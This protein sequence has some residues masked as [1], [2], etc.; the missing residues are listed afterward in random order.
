MPTYVLNRTHSLCTKKGHTLNFQKGVPLY[1]PNECVADVVAIG[2][3]STDG[4]DFDPL[5]PEN[6]EKV[7]LTADERREA[8]YGAY[9]LLEK[10]DVRGDF[11][12][13]GLPNVKV[14]A[15]VVGFM[16]Q[17]A[18]RNETWQ[19]YRESKAE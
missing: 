7:E 16:P 12:A 4:E 5:G 13:Q 18:E 9:A 2:G 3:N 1:V 6:T 14:L 8:L 10:R 15:G 11:N 19:T 17:T